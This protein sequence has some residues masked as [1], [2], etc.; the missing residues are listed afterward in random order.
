MRIARA[1]S[2]HNFRGDVSFV[3]ACVRV[4]VRSHV[5][6]MCV[7][8]WRSLV[9]WRARIVRMRSEALGTCDEIGI[10]VM[11]ACCAVAR[12]LRL[13]SYELLDVH[14]MCFCFFV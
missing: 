8:V 11:F 12:P 2:H 4:R 3:K 14:Y 13:G 7:G 5:Q 10:N 1:I 6:C 9:D